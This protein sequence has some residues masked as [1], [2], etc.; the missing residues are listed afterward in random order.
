[1]IRKVLLHLISVMLLTK[2][3][4]ERKASSD[5]RLSSKAQ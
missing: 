2:G 3:Q 1:M 4:D 5:E